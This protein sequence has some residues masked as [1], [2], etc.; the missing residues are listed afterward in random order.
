VLGGEAVLEGEPTIVALANSWIIINVGGGPTD[1]KPGVTLE[2][3]RNPDRVSSF[4]NIRVADIQSLYEQW[5]AR[6]ADFLTPPVN[7]GR[8]I[9]AYIRDPDGHLIEVG[10]TTGPV[11]Q[12]TAKHDPTMNAL[13]NPG[14]RHVYRLDAELDAPV[15][16]GDTPQGHRRIIPLTRGH[17]VGPYFEAELLPVGGADWQIVRAS[18]SSVADIRYTLKT[19]R[20][21][22]LYVQSKGVRHG[23]PD[24]LARL[25]AGEGVD[26]S[27]YTFRTSVTIETADAELAW[28]NDGVFIAVGGRWPSGVAYE[29]YLVA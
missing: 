5:S 8:E 14:L 22:L 24:V 9:R 19:D 29:V 16:L 1:D 7:N 3:P 26:P 23:D 13:P 18:G 6:G 10:Q 11:E 4:L 2:A 12:R 20:G 15:D 25:A 17:A 27:E 21:A 28:L